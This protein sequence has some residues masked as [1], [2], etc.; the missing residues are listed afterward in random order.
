MADTTTDTKVD[1]VAA[2]TELPLATRTR[3]AATTLED[4][5]RRMGADTFVG[6][7]SGLRDIADE[8]DVE[9]AEFA[10]VRE[11]RDT[12][13]A[14]VGHLIM[15]DPVDAATENAARYILNRGYRKIQA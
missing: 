7:P 9:D 2:F 10:E 4:L 14:A 13:R 5:A 3:L 8:I 12:I 1:A 11:L 15:G 6:T